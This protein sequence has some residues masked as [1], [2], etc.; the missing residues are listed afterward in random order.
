M[1]PLIEK[2]L[3][4]SALKLNPRSEGQELVVPVPRCLLMR[5]MFML[6]RPLP[7]LLLPTR[8]VKY[9]LLQPACFQD[10]HLKE[11]QT[12]AHLAPV[13][14]APQAAHRT[15]AAL[16]L[17]RGAPAAGC[18]AATVSSACLSAC[19]NA[20]TTDNTGLLLASGWP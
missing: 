4:T 7:M 3:R 18:S 5:P 20:C 17:G 15:A 6:P 1:V 16:Q 8:I 13:Q 12:A 19:W 10:L 9:R 14:Q 2:A 11:R